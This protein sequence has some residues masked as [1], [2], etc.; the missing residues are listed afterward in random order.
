MLVLSGELHQKLKSTSTN[1]DE[2]KA[3]NS[4][5]AADANASSRILLHANKL[6]AF[7]YNE[8]NHMQFS[9]VNIESLESFT[10]LVE[11]LVGSSVSYGRWYVD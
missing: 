4:Q 10:S 3:L 11:C 5:Y 8:S 9:E 2:L 6:K 7:L 1:I